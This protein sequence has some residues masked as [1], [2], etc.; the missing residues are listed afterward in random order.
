MNS[1]GVVSSAWGRVAADRPAV[2]AIGVA[3]T[4]VCLAV[5]AEV[6]FYLPFTP[7]PVTL[8]TFFVL[9][10]GVGLGPRLGTV[11]LSAY[12]AVGAVGVPIF[13]GDWLGPTTGY[14]LGFVAAGW[15]AGT[16]ARGVERP[17]TLRILVAML[18]GEAVILLLGAAYLAFCLGLGVPVAIEKGVVPF[19]AGDALKLAA[20]LA[21][22]RGLRG[23]LRG[24]FP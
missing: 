10:A 19:L 2:A 12:L 15:L 13:T 8:Q 18:A 3:A 14:L 9:A 1:S 21:L 4:V 23:R 11:A 17:S 20:A 7:V 24:L 5:A 22:C 6:R 16:V